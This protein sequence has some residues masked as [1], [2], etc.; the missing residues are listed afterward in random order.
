MKLIFLSSGSPPWVIGVMT[1]VF[2][3]F[4]YIIKSLFSK[5]SSKFSPDN[6]SE[7]E[8]QIFRKQLDVRRKDGWLERIDYWIEQKNYDEALKLLNI[9]YLHNQN[10]DVEFQKRRRIVIDLMNIKK[11]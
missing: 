1:I 6:S 5:V 3:I 10:H 11:K 4:F 9:Y 8:K 7:K 2:L